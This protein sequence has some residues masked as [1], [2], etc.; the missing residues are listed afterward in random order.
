M[1][2]NLLE[3]F[4]SQTYAVAAAAVDRLENIFKILASKGYFKNTSFTLISELDATY[5]LKPRMRMVQSGE[6]MRIYLNRNNIMRMMMRLHVAENS[7]H[8]L[9]M[10]GVDMAV[11]VRR[12]LNQAWISPSDVRFIGRDKIG[13]LPKRVEGQ[14]LEYENAGDDMPGI[15]R[16]RAID[17]VLFSWYATRILVDN[18]VIAIDDVGLANLANTCL[19]GNGI[20]YLE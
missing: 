19:L 16:V 12:C 15:E 6:D 8:L 5:A 14:V 1:D 20:V 18:P 4:A 10:L 2:Q 3:Y 7:H 13:P 11:I 9:Q 17:G